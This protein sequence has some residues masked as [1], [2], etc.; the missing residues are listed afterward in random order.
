MNTPE[1][2]LLDELR[3]FARAGVPPSHMLREV[4][5][6]VGP[7][8]GDRQFLVRLVS[9]AFLFRE[10]EGF[11][12]FGWQPDASGELSDHQLDSLLSRRIQAARPRWEAAEGQPAA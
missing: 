10:G 6:R 2:I 12:V 11:V 9:D 3:T 1:P 8:R 4:V 7:Q 5:R